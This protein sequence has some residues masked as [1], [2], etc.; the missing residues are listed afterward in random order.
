MRTIVIIA[1][2]TAIGKTKLSIDLARR[3]DGEIISADSMQV[4][5]DMRI[6]SQAPTLA[7]KKRV[8]H[9]LTGLLD[10]SKEYNVAIFI[11]KASGIIDSIA[12]KGKVPVVVGGSGLYIKGL[13]YGLFPSPDADMKFRSRMVK[14]I[15]RYGS[16]KLHARLAK[17][18]PESAGSIHP[19]DARR[20]VRALEIYD[21]TGKTMTELKASTHG[22]GE[23]YNIKIFALTRPREEIYSRIDERVDKMF[24]AGVVGEVKRLRRKRLSKTARMALGFGEICAYLEGRYGLDAAKDILK[25]NTRRF[26]KRQLTW[27][28]AD[29]KIG[30]FDMSE[31][32]EK[33]VIK[34]IIKELD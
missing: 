1:G 2:P 28:R 30:W 5:K 25:M 32:R 19:N 6:L 22:L 13:V 9:H 15:A 14:F 23:R 3:I 16:R 10:P 26:A 34:K 24:R 27:F 17:I 33:D 4:Y 12:K 20:I 18:D 21:S 11:K 8:K 29:K 7:E 31:M